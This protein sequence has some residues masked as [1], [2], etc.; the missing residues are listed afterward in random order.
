[1]ATKAL[2]L[3]PRSSTLLG[4]V[5]AAAAMSFS[6]LSRLARLA[7]SWWFQWP[8]ASYGVSLNAINTSF[9]VA[10]SCHLPSMICLVKNHTKWEK[11]NTVIWSVVWNTGFCWIDIPH[12]AGRLLY[13]GWYPAPFKGPHFCCLYPSKYSGLIGF[14]QPFLA[15]LVRATIQF[16]SRKMLQLW[17]IKG[18]STCEHSKRWPT[19]RV[20]TGA[21]SMSGPTTTCRLSLRGS[22]K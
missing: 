3:N 16:V 21:I 15:L 8:V 2:S 7:S 20:S 9:Q 13:C 6:E 12:Y 22:Y 17:Q 11:C 4:D 5:S 19:K 18:K 10:A 1:M 14:H